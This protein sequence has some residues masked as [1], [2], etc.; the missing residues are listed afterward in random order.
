M[1]S[2]LLWMTLPSARAARCAARMHFNWRAAAPT[3]GCDRSMQQLAGAGDNDCFGWGV[4]ANPWMLL[5]PAAEVHALA[6]A[7]SDLLT[8]AEEAATHFAFPTID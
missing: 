6:L 3:D 5:F 4:A 8:P 7:L 2:V 1:R